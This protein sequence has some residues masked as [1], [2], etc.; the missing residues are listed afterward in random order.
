MKRIV[1]TG[2]IGALLMAGCE[3]S[4]EPT[5]PACGVGEY[6]CGDPNSPA[7]GCIPNDW[8]CCDPHGDFCAYPYV[9]CDSPSGCC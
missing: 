1:L 7:S 3:V 8:D 9:C 5:H 4:V 2:I 6:W